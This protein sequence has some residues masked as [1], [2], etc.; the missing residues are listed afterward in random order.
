MRLHEWYKCEHC[1]E[2][3][4]VELD[5]FLKVQSEK[6][7]RSAIQ[8]GL[9]THK[10]EDLRYSLLKLILDTSAPQLVRQKFQELDDSL[11]W[12]KANK[13]PKQYIQG[14]KGHS[15][16]IRCLKANQCICAPKSTRL[17]EGTS[18]DLLCKVATIFTAEPSQQWVEITDF[19]MHMKPLWFTGQRVY[20]FPT[21]VVAD[22]SICRIRTICLYNQ[23]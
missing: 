17:F 7:V 11:A 9:L 19:K 14:L 10:M 6:A 23:D 21:Q 16:V 4:P 1:P 12:C 5:V 22:F 20:Q 8:D 13:L 2:F 15:H 18:C 3:H